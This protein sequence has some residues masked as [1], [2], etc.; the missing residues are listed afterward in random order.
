[1]KLLAS[2]MVEKVGSF[3]H[4]GYISAHPR[5]LYSEAYPSET[6]YVELKS[7][8]LNDALRLEGVGGG[9]DSASVVSGFSHLGP[10]VRLYVI[11][12]LAAVGVL[13]A[14][15]LLKNRPQR[16][17]E[18]VGLTMMMC[19][20]LFAFSNCGTRGTGPPRSESRQIQSE[21]RA[22]LP[23]SIPWQDLSLRKYE[24][25]AAAT[26][27]IMKGIIVPALSNTRQWAEAL[28]NIQDEVGLPTDSPTEGMKY[29]IDSYGLDG[30]G[31]EF[32]L[33]KERSVTREVTSAG[34]D[35]R[36]DS[37]DDISVRVRLTTNG[38]WG[39]HRNAFYLV[40]KDSVLRV[41]FHVWKSDMAITT[42]ADA[43][44]ALTGTDLFDF[45]TSAELPEEA[46]SMARDA[47]ETYAARG[48]SDTVILQYWD[49]R[50]DS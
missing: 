7:L 27:A 32:R 34:P 16:I 40:E 35:G 4:A 28:E 49:K 2:S 44:R 23:T 25:P 47:Y 9:D 50:R 21:Q 18:Y 17:F 24:D 10:D 22:P 14:L 37:E 36:F 38:V 41:F 29:A 8:N 43:S 46:W 42:N 39:F 5:R 30:W 1:M 6:K 12:A 11:G 26:V 45:F 20:G 48:H 31:R 13:L 19:C 3:L 33:S 15:W